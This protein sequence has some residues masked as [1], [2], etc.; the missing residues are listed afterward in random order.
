[1][2]VQGELAMAHAMI[3]L[4]RWVSREEWQE[5]LA[6]V[7]A[8]HL[9]AACEDDE[10]VIDE[11]E[12]V[13][14]R[15]AF[16]DAWGAACEDFITRE[17]EDGRNVA[18]NYLKRRGWKESPANRDYIKALRHSVVSL[19]EVL[20]VEPGRHFTLRDLI[21]GGE[22]VRVDEPDRSRH[23]RPND[24]LGARV[25]RVRQRMRTSETI[26]GL[27]VE[28]A[29]EI[30][31]SLA[32]WAEQ[33]KA[34]A[35]EIAAELGRPDDA[36]LI[37]ELMSPEVVLQGAAPLFTDLWLREILDEVFA[38]PPPRVVN[39]DGDMIELAT[40]VYTL[41]DGVTDAALDAAFAALSCVEDAP[42]PPEGPMPEP[43]DSSRGGWTIIWHWVDDTATH[44]PDAIEEA[45]DEKGIVRLDPRSVSGLP[46][47]GYLARRDDAVRLAANTMARL[48]R[49]R[50]LLEPA[51][52]G[53]VGPPV[54]ELR[55]MAD[56][57]G[58]IFER[59]ADDGHPADDDR[60][61]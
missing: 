56:L 4:A 47:L 50:A 44:D 57:L 12:D 41:A 51:L 17:L 43:R 36:A 6:K 15:E 27:S 32:D 49:G 24:L 23:V 9:G 21:R 35:P 28:T 61:A 11:L 60:P 52:S 1:M 8:E 20:E 25:F 59:E 31:E 37:E 14:G 54:V 29:E 22:P 13:I 2:P 53:L 33:A 19:Y 46:V 7:V 58:E 10:V 40:A 5:E 55:S 39:G 48:E 38:T 26:L 18:E 30:Q 34:R 16:I 45:A 3:G 42:P